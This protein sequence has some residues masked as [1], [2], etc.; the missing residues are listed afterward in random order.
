MLLH[1]STPQEKLTALTYLANR[2][3]ERPED[4]AGGIALQAMAFEIFG[5]VRGQQLL[6]AI[7]FLNYRRQSIEFHLAGSPGWLSRG[8]IRTLF[9]YPFKHLNCLRLWCLIRRKNKPARVGA[10]RLGFKVLGV[11]ED[12]FG[13][14]RDGIIY[15][16]K[17]SDCRWIR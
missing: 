2:L 11:A 4:L 10:E 6:G 5:A 17:R 1:A 15:S 3:G 7:M 8:E 14:G 16:M 9:A 13:E 12:E